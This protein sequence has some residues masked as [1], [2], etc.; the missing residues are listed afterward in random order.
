MTGRTQGPGGFSA[1]ANF[2]LSL[3]TGGS[4][5]VLI[6]TVEP[7][8][9]STPAAIGTETTPICLTFI[10]MADKSEFG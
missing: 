4:A 3:Y 1:L 6:H 10:K 2:G 7:R 9:G 5:K 8:T